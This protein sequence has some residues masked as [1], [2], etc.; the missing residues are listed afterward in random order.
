MASALHV[1]AK[2]ADGSS[3]L[4]SAVRGR[5]IASEATWPYDPVRACRLA[6]DHYGDDCWSAYG[7]APGY[8]RDPALQRERQAADARGEWRIDGFEEIVPEVVTTDQIAALIA[9]GEALYASFAFHR[10]AWEATRGGRDVVPHYP[11]EAAPSAHAVTLEGYRQTPSGRQFL[12][13][14]SWGRDWGRDGYA[15]MDDAQVRTNLRYAYRVRASH[16][17]TPPPPRA[18]PQGQVPWLSDCV[19]IPS[20]T[21]LPSPSTGSGIPLPGTL[22]PPSWGTVPRPRLEQLPSLITFP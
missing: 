19:A 4:G 16:A 10:P 21:P 2:Y 14:N 18:C 11:R 22:L 13:H 1:F 5:A 15:W 6:D 9:G 12:I 17:S 3:D 8:G 7:V 20:L